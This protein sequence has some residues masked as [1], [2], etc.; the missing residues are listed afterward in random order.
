MLVEPD[1]SWTSHSF[2]DLLAGPNASH[3]CKLKLYLI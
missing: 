2:W 1:L 3:I